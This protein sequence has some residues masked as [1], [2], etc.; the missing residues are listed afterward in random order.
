MSFQRKFR[1]IIIR[2][3]TGLEII[4]RGGTKGLKI[5]GLTLIAEKFV[6]I[7]GEKVMWARNG[8]SSRK[9][10]KKSNRSDLFIQRR[11][12]VKGKSKKLVAAQI[13]GIVS[14]VWIPLAALFHLSSSFS[15][16]T[17]Q[18]THP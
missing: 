6:R 12:R 18:S 1:P 8:R 16:Q 15:F 7:F 13:L 3:I 17:C 4:R 14:V 9:T 2:E 10:C 11:G 5:T